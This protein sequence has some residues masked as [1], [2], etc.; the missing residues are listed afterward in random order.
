MVVP[1]AR[2]WGGG[3]GGGPQRAQ[4]DAV[5]AVSLQFLLAHED[6]VA[7]ATFWPSQEAQVPLS[8]GEFVQDV[9][10]EAGVVAL[11]GRHVGEAGLEGGAVVGAGLHEAAARVGKGGRAVEG[12]EGPL[13]A[14]F[15][16]LRG[17][18]HGHLRTEPTDVLG[19]RTETGRCL[20]CRCRAVEGDGQPPGVRVAEVGGDDDCARPS[21]P[22]LSELCLEEV[23]NSVAYD[24]D[25]RDDVNRGRGW[26]G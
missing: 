13:E 25:L 4:R 20:R 23:V 26:V 1:R 3:W 11:E 10:M 24:A 17:S 8:R 9:L 6:V 5:A 12:A 15:S 19:R 21:R 7:C 22:A 14:A 18:P 16:S 2:C